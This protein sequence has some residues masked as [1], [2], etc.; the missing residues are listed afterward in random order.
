MSAPEYATDAKALAEA[1]S[2]HWRTDCSDS[3][4]GR[5]VRWIRCRCGWQSA[6]S[7]SAINIPDLHRIW[8]THLSDELLASDWMRQHD[9]A[10]RAEALEQAAEE[11]AGLVPYNFELRPDGTEDPVRAAYVE[12]HHG[13]WSALRDRAARLRAGGDA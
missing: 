10:V 5:Y 12:G 2:P 7:E 1:L 4:E 9:D 3:S 8:N 13:A 11:V 6:A